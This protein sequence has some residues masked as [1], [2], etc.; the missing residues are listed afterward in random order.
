[1]KLIIDIPEDIQSTIEADEFINR[2]QLAVLQMHILNG[3][4]LEEYLHALKDRGFLLHSVDVLGKIREETEKIPTAFATAYTAK[5]EA[6][7]IIDK[8]RG[9]EITEHYKKLVEYYNG[10]DV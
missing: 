6:L 5:N 3:I 7:K 8:Y 9:D 4:P 1:M 10:K 2:E